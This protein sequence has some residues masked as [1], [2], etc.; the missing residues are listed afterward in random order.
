MEDTK[1]GNYHFDTLQAFFEAVQE[2]FSDPDKWSTKIY[3]MCMIV[4]GDRMAD[5]H[6]QIFKKAVHGLC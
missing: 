3:K 4:Q 1:E 6:V 5:K 2:E